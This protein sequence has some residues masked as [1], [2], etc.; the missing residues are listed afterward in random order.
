MLLLVA[1][2][3][4][5]TGSAA[6]APA[7][8]RSGDFAVVGDQHLRKSAFNKTLRQVN[9]KGSK[10]NIARREVATAQIQAAWYAGEV[11]AL[12][13]IITDKQVRDR[14]ELLKEQSFP[15]RSDYT[16]FLKKTGQTEH[17]L[18]KLVRGSLN[19]E[20]VEQRW[21]ADVTV[22]DEEVAARYN[23]DPARYGSPEFRDI[24]L[25]F[26]T[27]KKHAKLA[28][29]ALDNGQSFAKVA[30]KYSI[31]SLSRKHGGRFPAVEKE[32]LPPPIDGAIFSAQLGELIGP[33]KTQYGYYVVKI[34]K[35]TPA[36]AQTLAQAREEIVAYLKQE[37]SELPAQT[38]ACVG[39]PSRC[40][41]L[42]SR[43][44]TAAALC[45]DLDQQRPCVTVQAA[46]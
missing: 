13:I 3:A 42:L 45:A 2:S 43:R 31:N 5:I 40:V 23:E 38:S 34:R 12:G 27:S 29:A 15:R 25:V 19:Q 44:G 10:G 24:A 37:K 32:Q 18:L 22:T 26:T 6:A 14:F 46:S 9:K 17:E 20:A 36:E 21:G 1:F 39:A 33:V 35:I 28:R 4:A 7:Q 8:L 30:K 16:K 11:A 41:E